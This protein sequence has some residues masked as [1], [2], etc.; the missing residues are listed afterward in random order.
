MTKR[1][2]TKSALITSVLALFLCFAMLLG[3][4]FA[5]FT[6]SAASGSN[7]I[8]SGN[9]D[10]KVE[11][12]LDGENWKDLDGADDL[13][14]KGLWEPGHTEVVALRITNNGS[15]A[16]N[17]TANMN[18]VD[19]TVGKTQDGQDITLSD[20]L[21]VSSGT[22]G[23]TDQVDPF[24]GFNIS[25]KT[26]EVAFA[27][28]SSLVLTNAASFKESNVLESNQTLI[29]GDAQYLIIR[30]DMPET[31]GN[32]ANHDGVNIP[33]IE[34]G[35]NVFA[36]QATVESDTF[37]KDYDA[38]N[39][40]YTVA[41]ANAAMLADNKNVMLV[42][43]NESESVLEIPAAYTAT[44]TI[45]NSRVKSVQAAGDANVAIQGSVVVNAKGSGLATFAAAATNGSAITAE[46]TLNISGSGIL[47][48]IAADEVGAF[49]IGGMTTDAINIEGVT[50]ALAKGGFAY[51]VGTDTKYYK[52]APEGG[53][54][55][56]SSVN[57][58]DITLK[59]VVV[60]KAIGG[61]KA[62]AIGAR[63]H[64]GVDVTI[65][66]STIVYAEGGVSAA[67]IGGSRVSGDASETGTSI[68]IENSTVTAK[69]GAYGAG[70]GSGYDTHCGSKQ[71]MCTINISD[72]TI[73]ATGGKY[74]AGIGTGYHNAA[75]NG[76]IKDSTVTAASGEKLYKD[77]YTLA[78]DIGFGVVDPAREGQQ[79]DSYIIYNGEKITLPTLADEW[80]GTADTTW[81][82]ETDTEFV[83]DTA[84]ELAGF[85]ELANSGNKFSRKTIV[86][87]SDMDLN[88]K[89]WTP[90]NSFA[91]TLDG[92]DHTIDNFSIDA[93]TNHGGFINVLEWG[94]VK[95]L[96]LTGV[97][98]TVGNYRFGVLARSINQS[99][100]DNVTVKDVNVTTTAPTAFVA[101]LFAHGTV[102]SNMEVNNCTVEN[103]TVNAENGAMIIGGITC[104]VQKN[105]TE[106]EGTNIFE[107]LNVKNFKVIANDTDGYCNIGGL[108]G[109]TQ[110]VWQ[111]PRFNNCSVSG[112]DVTATGT[113]NVGGFMCAP[114]SY[115]YAEDCTVEG[116]IDVSGVTSANNYAGGF[117]GDYGWGDNVGK[118]DH[119]VTNCV[120]DVDITTKYAS[121]GGFVGSGTNSEG[122]NKN[123]TLTNCEAKGTVS[124]VDGGT[125]NVGGFAGQ[126]DRG[127][128][129]NC[130][131]A[132]DPFI[133]KV[134]DGYTLVDDGNG[135]LTVTK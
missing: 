91:G 41:D 112:L 135:T 9:L 77:T 129:I 81:Y 18:I 108:V 6:D 30:V 113:V 46:G 122:R 17:Y 84:E 86:L 28:D 123:I 105:G 53:A 125:A 14:Q 42:G 48:A 128:Y 66:D 73:N 126:T 117:F 116:K 25:E 133:G 13:F 82:N 52:D 94:T 67:A 21:V 45:V 12:T 5:W 103:L 96:T 31:V 99:N 2:S 74:A 107:N 68:T 58:A 59:N 60:E 40:V 47:T 39:A 75:L 92:N 38:G 119:K 20:I 15:L 106:A 8:K 78:M 61:S 62:A 102:N 4:T 76:E 43:A 110:S 101:G 35:I 131:A 100:I 34:F 23:I 69:G 70:I 3:S 16:L 29:A 44:L 134:L 51:G 50:I 36:T 63:Y 72:S 104:F 83:L 1:K 19:E 27:D 127:I 85:V 65:E 26:L 79:T 37:G 109:Q 56:G 57:G 71:P 89:Q 98:A 88:G 22:Y 121:A 124:L 97:T 10:I 130:F 87:E 95:D 118:G 54:A 64:V 132:Q 55:I 49:G 90:I 111:N 115:T 11:Y 120:A 33:K 93:T 24:F 114:G 7:V 80:D 32:E